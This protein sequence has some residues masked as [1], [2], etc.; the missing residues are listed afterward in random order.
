M[1]IKSAESHKL[2]KLD[3][4]SKEERVFKVLNDLS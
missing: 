2:N 4:K 1:R 3:I